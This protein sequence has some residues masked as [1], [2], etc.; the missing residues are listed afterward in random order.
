MLVA[1]IVV[2]VLGAALVLVTLLSAIRIFVLPRAASDRLARVILRLVRQLFNLRV[3]LT[4]SFEQADSVMALYAP[5]SLVALLFFWLT[6]LMLGYAAMFWAVGEPPWQA[7][8]ISGSS[9]F[10]LGSASSGTVAGTLLSFSE[11][12][13]GMLLVALLISY[14]PTIYAA[15]AR[16][17]ATV[18]MLAVR[19]GPLNDADHADAEV[20]SAIRMLCRFHQLGGLESL[21]EIWKS[22]ESWFVEVEESHTSLAVLTFY[23]SPRPNRSWVTAAGTVLDAAALRLSTL[24]LP[25]DMFAALCIRAGFIALRSIASFFQIDFNA[26]P[27]P[28]TPISLSRADFDRACAQMREADVP[29]KADLDQ[30]WRDFVGWRVNYDEV[31]LALCTITMAPPSPWSV[32]SAE[33]TTTDHTPA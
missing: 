9:L 6:L 2:F 30:A 19:A 27:G 21:S 16:R 14:L 15:F 26:N 11:A 25:Y 4:R 33:V 1:R 10:T 32:A 24:D 5:I 22:W 23:R 18:A 29:L 13:I 7:L 8:Q 3:R 31:L 28:E 12:A 20:P 17:E